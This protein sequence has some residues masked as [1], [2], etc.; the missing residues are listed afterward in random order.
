M[1]GHSGPG[2]IPD[3]PPTEASSPGSTTPTI[4]RKVKRAEIHTLLITCPP[5]PVD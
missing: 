1:V 2:I 4:Q 5:S 3:A